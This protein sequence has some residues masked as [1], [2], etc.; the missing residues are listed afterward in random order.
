[1]NKIINSIWIKEGKFLEM[2]R[3]SEDRIRNTEKKYLEITVTFDVLEF[4]K[5]VLY[6]RQP[7]L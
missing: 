1:M 2:L 6:A 7:N 5:S 3:E 4:Q